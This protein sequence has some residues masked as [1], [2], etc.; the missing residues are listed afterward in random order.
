MKRIYLIFCIMLIPFFGISQKNSRWAK[1]TTPE[2]KIICDESPWELVF[3]DNFDGNALDLSKWE[4]YIGV[5]RDLYFKG[6]KAWHKAENVIVADGLLTLVSKREQMDSMPVVKKWSPYTVERE[7][8]EYT[9]GEIWTKTQFTY[10]KLEARLKIPKG[11]GFFPAFWMYGYRNSRN[12]EIDVFEFANEKRRSNLGRIHHST[13]HY[14]GKHRS[15]QYKGADFSADFHV[16]TMVWDENKIEF[17][18]D[19]ILKRRDYKYKKGGKGVDCQ[20]HTGKKYKENKVFTTDPMN[21]ILNTAIQVGKNAPNETTPFPA[22]MEVDYVRYYQ[23]L[24]DKVKQSVHSQLQTY[25]IVSTSL[26]M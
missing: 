22:Y 19:G 13:V 24:E 11:W 14:N 16:F 6:Q 9:S 20:L 2:D 4:P 18:V 5:P 25:Q 23:R 26:W 10:G 3:E 15:T 17:Y 7:D 21:I 8:F 1:I 12:N